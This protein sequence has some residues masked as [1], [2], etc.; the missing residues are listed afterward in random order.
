MTTKLI[1]T[2][3]F[4][5]LFLFVFFPQSGFAYDGQHE[6]AY[7]EKGI[8]IYHSDRACEVIIDIDDSELV[9]GP[10]LNS[11]EF[12][13]CDFCYGKSRELIENTSF[14]K[15][16][17]SVNEFYDRFLINFT[18]ILEYKK[19]DIDPATLELSR[20]VRDI[21][22]FREYHTINPLLDANLYLL[23]DKEDEVRCAIIINT[24]KDNDID[25]LKAKMQACAML[26]AFETQK[27]TMDI[28][29]KMD[30]LVS[31]ESAFLF[32]DTYIM[33][34]KY[35]AV[36]V[37]IIIP[38]WVFDYKEFN[39]ASEIDYYCMKVEDIIQNTDL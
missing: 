5:V 30:E 34:S 19:I 35:R 32:G 20:P 38:K 37:Y 17:P 36:I 26:L 14:E 2:S 10:I 1:K 33:V 12:R 21:E 13:A 24:S 25:T 15:N 31:N 23:T 39:I 22:D 16:S 11:K 18:E 3:L 29:K 9:I 28:V 8:P 4:I 27:D 7:W 6:I